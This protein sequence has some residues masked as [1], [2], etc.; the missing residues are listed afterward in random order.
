MNYLTLNI[1]HEIAVGE[2]TVEEARGF[3]ASNAIAF[4]TGDTSLFMHELL[5]T[6]P[7]KADDPDKPIMDDKAFKEFIDRT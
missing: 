4:M 5:F 7:S 2:R 6:P 1:A 3:L